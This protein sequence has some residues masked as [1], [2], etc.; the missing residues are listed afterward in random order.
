MLRI[1][2]KVLAHWEKGIRLAHDA[3]RRSWAPP[4]LY[5]ALLELDLWEGKARAFENFS[6]P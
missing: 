2:M 4:L 5:D 1:A 6:R 3:T